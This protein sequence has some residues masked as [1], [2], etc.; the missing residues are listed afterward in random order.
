MSEVTVTDSISIDLTAVNDAP[1]EA[2]SWTRDNCAG[3]DGIGYFDSAA[4]DAAAI[5]GGCSKY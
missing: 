4:G 3:I 5:F 1:V 2:Q